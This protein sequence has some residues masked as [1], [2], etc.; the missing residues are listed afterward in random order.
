MVLVQGAAGA[1]GL[2]AVALAKHAGAPVIATVRSER[3]ELLV[4]QA[5]ADDVVRTDGFA[6]DEV[7]ER[8]RTLAPDGMHHVVEVAFH[9]NIVIDA[10][11]APCGWTRPSD[12]VSRRAHEPRGPGIGILIP[13]ER[14]KRA[15]HVVHQQV[16]RT[17]E[18]SPSRNHPSRIPSSARSRAGVR[19]V[20]C[21]R[22]SASEI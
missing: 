3:D 17:Q 16:E 10:D 19:S 15:V 1:V 4:A 14:R 8:I 5:S 9:A 7:I 6:I 22:G 20:E 13:P 11:I 21:A 12:A 2:S 18:V